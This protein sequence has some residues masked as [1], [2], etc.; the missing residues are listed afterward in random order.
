MMTREGW[1]QSL[2]CWC[3]LLLCLELALAMT[4]PIKHPEIMTLESLSPAVQPSGAISMWRSAPFLVNLQSALPAP[5]GAMFDGPD[6]GRAA[7]NI[8]SHQ[9]LVYV[10]D[11]QGPNPNII[12]IPEGCPSGYRRDPK[13]LCRI[14][15]GLGYGPNPFHSFQPENF[16]GDLQFYTGLR[17]VGRP[18]SRPSRPL[19]RRPRLRGRPRRPGPIQGSAVL[20]PAQPP[21]QASIQPA[22][23]QPIPNTDSQNNNNNNDDDDD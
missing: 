8:I 9:L 6:P 3:M 18:S 5:P 13:G 1:H 7:N 22:I 21:V 14:I 16:K 10:L 23:V 20:G 19:R 12:N 2:T 17:Q 11:D 15:L 4:T